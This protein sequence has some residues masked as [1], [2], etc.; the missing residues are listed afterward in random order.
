MMLDYEFS[1]LLADLCQCIQA[2]LYLSIDASLK[3]RTTLSE[4]CQAGP[5]SQGRGETLIGT[6]ER[7]VPKAKPCS[8]ALSVEHTHPEAPALAN[9]CKPPT[10]T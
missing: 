2:L 4:D 8:A 3:Q 5:E 7:M 1:P 6:E 9:P 10:L